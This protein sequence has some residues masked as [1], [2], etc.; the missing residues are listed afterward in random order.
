MGEPKFKIGDKIY[1]IT[2]ESKEGII[3]NIIYYFSTR[4]FEYIITTGWGEEYSCYEY[5]LVKNKIF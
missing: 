2:K 3:V 5:E 4:R 1:H